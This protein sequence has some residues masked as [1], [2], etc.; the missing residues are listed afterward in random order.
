MSMD[1]PTAHEVVN[2]PRLIPRFKEMLDYCIATILESGLV[3]S[4]S[5]DSATDEIRYHLRITD[6]DRELFPQI[7]RETEEIWIITGAGGNE[8]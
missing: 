7:L 2:L 5:Y 6:D 3:G 4:M 1:I 8:S